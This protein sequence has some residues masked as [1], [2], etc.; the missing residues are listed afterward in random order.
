[1]PLLILSDSMSTIIFNVFF[2]ISFVL[3]LKLPVTD[4]TKTSLHNLFRCHFLLSSCMFLERTLAPIRLDHTSCMFYIKKPIT[5]K[6]CRVHNCFLRII[7]NMWKYSYIILADAMLRLYI[8]YNLSV[9]FM[10]SKGFVS[11]WGS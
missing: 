9:D 8:T 7:T 3:L 10:F 4:V 2:Q 6:L 1:V 11:N 5:L